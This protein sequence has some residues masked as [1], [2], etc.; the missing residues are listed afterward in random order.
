MKIIYTLFFLLPTL[1]FAQTAIQGSLWENGNSSVC[2][3]YFAD[4][5]ACMELIPEKNENGTTAIRFIF[6]ARNSTLTVVTENTNGSNFFVTPTDSIKSNLKHVPKFQ[7]TGTTK[8]FEQI[9]LCTKYQAKSHQNEFMA[10][11]FELPALDL[12][13]FKDF[14]KSDPL[15]IFLTNEKPNYFPAQSIIV[16]ANGELQFSYQTT[17]VSTNFMFSVFDIPSEAVEIK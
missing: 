16:K 11:L 8:E 12:S 1:S 6:N 13:Q 10:F 17:S 9:G 14:F 5:R 15:F 2:N 3:W 4:D 7:Q